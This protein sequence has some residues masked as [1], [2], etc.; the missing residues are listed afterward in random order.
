MGL[1][2]LGKAYTTLILRVKK[3]TKLHIYIKIHLHFD[4]IMTFKKIWSQFF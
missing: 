2:I 4:R 3:K 1:R